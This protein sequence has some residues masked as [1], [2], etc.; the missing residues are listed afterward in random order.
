MCAQERCTGF[1]GEERVNENRE[2]MMFWL[3]STQMHTANTIDELGPTPVRGKGP[4]HVGEYM[5]SGG[6]SIEPK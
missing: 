6:E 1:V 3:Q 4:R 2:I 5:T